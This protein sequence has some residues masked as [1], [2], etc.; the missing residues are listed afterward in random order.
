MIIENVVSHF[1]VTRSAKRKK[2]E[3]NQEKRNK[4]YRFIIRMISLF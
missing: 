3:T 1:L 2:Q 4:P